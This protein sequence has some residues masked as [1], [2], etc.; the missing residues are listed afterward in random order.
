MKLIA[1]VDIG[2]STTEVCIAAQDDK[3]KIR[4]LSEG[5]TF[6]TGLKGTIDNVTGVLGVL[7][8]TVTTAGIKISDLSLIRINEAV[9]V[10]GGA[11]METLTRTIVTES[12]MIGHNPKTP[13]GFGTAAGETVRIENLSRAA[14]NKPYIAVVSAD[15]DY[16]SAAELLNSAIENGINIVGAILQLDEAVLVHNRLRRKIPIVD[17]VRGIDKIKENIECAIEVALPGQ[18]VRMLSNPYGI[19][20]LL[21]LSAD[22][23]QRVVP[24]AKS[25]IG[26]KSA[27][28]MKTP[29]EFDNQGAREENIDEV[30]ERAVK[31][32]VQHIG[33]NAQ[34]LDV[35]TADTF[36]HVE[37]AGAF[38]GET[39]LEKAVVVAALV[40][41]GQ[42]PMEAIANTL[43]EKTGVYTQVSGVEPVMA[44]LG[45]LTTPG[46]KL[47]LIVLDLGGGS[48]DAAIME[49]SGEVKSVCL[50]GA[51]ELVTLMI[52]TRLG[53]SN[54]LTAENIKK[55]PA[56]KVESMFH[57]RLEN[58]DVMFFEEGLEPRF[59]GAVVLL[60]PE[61][62]IKVEEEIPIEK[63]IS[64]RVEAKRD[65]FVKNALRAVGKLTT[66][67]VKNVILVGGSAEDFE[68]PELISA[69]FAEM[70]KVCGRGNIRGSQGPRNAVATGLIMDWGS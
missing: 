6:T 68:I 63:I 52:Q 31:N 46:A 49:E 4:F 48:T 28:V 59:F 17:E 57:I 30:L 1:A 13:A 29:Y 15:F 47:P 36:A 16:E 70:G 26:N 8:E 38:A 21:K 42:L 24:I 11:A 65:V 66:T 67:D 40:T 9:P 64:A 3:G 61:G 69:A 34:I 43:S 32:V 33:E 2:N 37:V 35:F 62:M 19:A 22:E 41:A 50:A 23:T 10:I 5:S 44:T 60:A 56:A 20:A 39:S 51:G 58:G 53:L 45:A 54:R 12:S 55:Y 25:L 14:Q 27:V 18:S 7:D